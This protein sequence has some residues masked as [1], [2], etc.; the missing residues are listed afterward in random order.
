MTYRLFRLA[1]GSYDVLLNGVIIA[2]LVQSGPTNDA[3]W[4]VELLVDL[5]QR[6]CRLP[7]QRQNI[8]SAAWKRPGSGLE[9]R[10]SR[11]RRF[12][13]RTSEPRQ[14]QNRFIWFEMSRCI[15]MKLL[16]LTS[17]STPPAYGSTMRPSIEHSASWKRMRTHAISIPHHRTS[18]RL[19]RR[20]LPSRPGRGQRFNRAEALLLWPLTFQ[21]RSSANGNAS[22][23]R[24]SEP[25]TGPTRHL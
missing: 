6:K 3:T 19:K 24:V 12:K 1:P 20:R 14:R 25:G 21:R 23:S 10:N 7:S 9:E 4:T 8:R 22:S 5:P 16:R 13:V 15:G 18:P 2:S 11:T 17:S